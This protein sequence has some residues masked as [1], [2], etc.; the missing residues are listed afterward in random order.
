MT[1]KEQ[2]TLEKLSEKVDGM[3][4]QLKTNTEDTADIKL[5]LAGWTGGRKALVWAIG[6]LGTI[7]IIASSIYEGVRS[8]VR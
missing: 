5:Q 3:V 6:I 7:G 1:R 4:V 2:E 8:A